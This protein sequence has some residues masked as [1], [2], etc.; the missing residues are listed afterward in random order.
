MRKVPE[1]GMPTE[2]SFTFYVPQATV[3]LLMKKP[4][5]GA[6]DSWRWSLFFLSSYRLP[7]ELVPGVEGDHD[8]RV[9]VWTDGT[10]GVVA[11]GTKGVVDN[12]EERLREHYIV[13]WPMRSRPGYAAEWN[14]EELPP[15]ESRQQSPSV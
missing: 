3:A 12:V 7:N 4:L 9:V 2:E 5:G 1:P 13:R 14:L 15:G 8:G 11:H 6:P 10:P